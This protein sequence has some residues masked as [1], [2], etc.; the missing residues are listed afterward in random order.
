[1]CSFR[2]HFSLSRHISLKD[3][4]ATTGASRHSVQAPSGGTSREIRPPTFPIFP[5]RAINRCINLEVFAPNSY[6]PA[7]DHTKLYILNARLSANFGL[8]S[9]RTVVPPADPS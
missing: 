5:S 8:G 3:L 7:V 1:M 6:Q 2:R 9:S 4:G